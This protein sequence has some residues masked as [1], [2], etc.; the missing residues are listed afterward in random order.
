MKRKWGRDLPDTK[1]EKRPNCPQCGFKKVYKAG[2]KLGER[3]YLCPICGRTFT[4][5]NENWRKECVCCE[6]KNLKKLGSYNK[7]NKPRL[8]CLDCKCTFYA[9]FDIDPEVIQ[10]NP[11]LN[12]FNKRTKHKD[13]GCERGKELPHRN[14]NCIHYEN[15]LDSFARKNEIFKCV[16]CKNY[17]P[18]KIG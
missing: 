16:E 15:C 18:Y 11:Q 2:Y 1:Y 10:Q 12:T 7:K 8:Q 13:N 5:L 3:Y 14:Y 4:K 6:S 17:V 9:E